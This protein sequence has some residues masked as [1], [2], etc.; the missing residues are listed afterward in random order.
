MSWQSQDPTRRRFLLRERAERLPDMFP[1]ALF[2][3]IEEVE[4][5]LQFVEMVLSRN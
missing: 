5:I 2:A 1:D 3:R 4:E